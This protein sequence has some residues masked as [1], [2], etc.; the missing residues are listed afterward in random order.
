M[1]EKRVL[2][3]GGGPDAEHEVSL[4]SSAAVTEALNQSGRYVA[5]RE[6]IG[7]LTLEGLRAMPG[8]VVFPVLHGPWG[9]GG[10]M[11]RLLEADGRPFAGCGSIAARAAIDKLLTKQVCLSLGIATGPSAILH[12][13]DDVPPIALP[14][15]LKPVHEGSSVGL[16][17]CTTLEQW[18]AALH[19]AR[20]AL[21]GGQSAA[22]MVEPLTKGRELTVGIV[23]GEA[24]PIVEITPADGVYDYAAKYTRDDTR[25]VV[26]PPLPEGVGH[27]M[28]RDALRLAGALGCAM[29]ARV[30]F[31]LGEHGGPQLLEANTM[32]GFTSH[33]LLP[34]AAGRAG[35]A[36]P[37]LCAALVDDAIARHGAHQPAPAA[38]R[39]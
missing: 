19:V 31:M 18:L 17:I 20:S 3:L 10:P 5:R 15:V 25:Y 37:E 38:V 14:L 36:M 16:A 1:S 30:D 24:M 6:V 29:L 9:E 11:Q 23:A 27:A 34:M 4:N 32:P 13:L 26:D 39:S 22:F 33:S 2:V 8:D 28:Q 21:A 12:P 35:L 7:A